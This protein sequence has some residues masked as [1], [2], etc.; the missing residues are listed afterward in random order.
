MGMMSDVA[1]GLSLRESGAYLALLLVMAGLSSAVLIL[2]LRHPNILAGVFVPG[3]RFLFDGAWFSA[4]GTSFLVY[5]ALM[6]RQP[7]GPPRSQSQETE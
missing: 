2:E 3:A 1:L 4:A 6:R 5:L 7:A